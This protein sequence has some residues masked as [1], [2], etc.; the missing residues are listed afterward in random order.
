MIGEIGGTEE[1]AAAGCRK[2][3]QTH[4]RFCRW[5]YRTTCK[6]MGH[7]GAIIL[8][9]KE[10][11]GKVCCIQAA[12]IACAK[13]PSELGSTLESLKKAGLGEIKE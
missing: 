4:S 3:H 11:Q 1:D 10:R 13:D 5:C 7:A 6:R 8:A 2:C 9:V 12:G